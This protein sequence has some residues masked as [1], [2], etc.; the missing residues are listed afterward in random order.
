MPTELAFDIAAYYKVL[1]EMRKRTTDR[2]KS[3]KVLRGYRR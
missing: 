1:R 2:L 3:V